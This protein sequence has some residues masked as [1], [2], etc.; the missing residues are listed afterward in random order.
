MSKATDYLSRRLSRWSWT[1][2]PV[3]RLLVISLAALSLGAAVAVAGTHHHALAYLVGFLIALVVIRWL[4]M[5][6]VRMLPAIALVVTLLVPTDSAQLPIQLQGIAI[7]IVPLVIWM[8]RSPSLRVSPIIRALALLFL[9]WMILSEILAPLHTNRGVAWLVTAGVALVLTVS[10]TPAG[11]EPSSFRALFLKITTV[12]GLYGLVEGFVLHRNIL[13]SPIFEHDTWWLPLKDNA[14]YRIT[15]LLGHPLV[16]GT[17]FAAAAVLA[18]SELIER[19]DKPWQ[20]YVRLLILMGAVLATHSRSA[21]IALAAGILAVII[22]SR[23][24]Q[25]GL[26]N[27]RV[28]LV[29][30]A[31]VSAGV[32]VLGLQARNESSGGLASAAFRVTVLKET[33]E[34]LHVV[35]PLGA[36]PG[37]SDAYRARVQLPGWETSLENS[38]S[39]V[40][41]SL[42]LTGLV[43]MCALLMGP[44]ILGLQSRLV[45]GEAAALLTVLVDIAG[46]NTIEG[47]TSVLVL[48]GLL[49]IAILTG[50]NAARAESRG[51]ADAAAEGLSRLR[52]D[53]SR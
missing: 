15:T 8:I 42:G 39:E 45:A 50:V 4:F 51:D 21:A 20:A 16:N 24:K 19:R 32:I 27:R 18:A 26:G 6:P 10:N 38:Y 31:I 43:L 29:I 1:V 53:A 25:L 14:S 40:A 33:V 5:V 30:T 46:F 47:H 52:A 9:S 34:A 23:A 13:F 49:M 35:G 48:M 41:V 44:V 11:L 36:G 37:Q 28:I 12:L 3:T 7:G 2:Q 17:V 22:F